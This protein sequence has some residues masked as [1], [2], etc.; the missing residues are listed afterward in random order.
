MRGAEVGGVVRHSFSDRLARGARPADKRLQSGSF[1]KI[2]ADYL[3]RNRL[4]PGADPPTIQTFVTALPGGG[5][6]GQTA[7]LP[8]QMVGS[9]G[10]RGNWPKS[11]RWR[12]HVRPG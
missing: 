7:G 10:G 11:F 4:T 8:K 9:D 6:S 12:P 2:E 3:G 1:A 5:R